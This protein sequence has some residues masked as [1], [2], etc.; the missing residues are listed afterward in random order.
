MSYG[1]L[2]LSRVLTIVEIVEL[3]KLHKDL[4]CIIS[5]RNRIVVNVPSRQLKL[6]FSDVLCLVEWLRSIGVSVWGDIMWIEHDNDGDIMSHVEI[7]SDKMPK[8]K[9]KRVRK[10][11]DR[12]SLFDL[13][14]MAIEELKSHKP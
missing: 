14:Q 8:V 7:D 6:E 5:E 11:N 9:M 10:C 3:Y 2:S 13:G 4:W 12:L 1:T